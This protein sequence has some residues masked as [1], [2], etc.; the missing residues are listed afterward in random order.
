MSDFKGTKK[1][2]FD[3][4]LLLFAKQGYKATTMRQI[5]KEVGIAQS[6]IYNHFKNKE[7]ILDTAIDRLSKSHLINIFEDKEPKELYKKGRLLL[8]NIANMFKLTTYDA[9]TDLLFRFMMQELFNN[10]RLGEFYNEEYYQKNVK[11][12][13]AIF[14][15]MMQ[16]DMIEA[17]DPLLLSNEFFAPLFFYQLQVIRLKADNKSTSAAATLFEKHTEFFWEKIRVKAPQQNSLF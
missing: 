4:A 14:F 2:I 11:K 10:D 17:T 16:D 15:M 8:K 3:T 1:K 5:G 9:K 6:A 13:S 7:A 12:L